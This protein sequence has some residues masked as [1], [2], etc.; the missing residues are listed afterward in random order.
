MAWS[1][2]CGVRT[3]ASWLRTMTK[4]TGLG[5]EHYTNKTGRTTGLGRYTKFE[6]PLL[7][8]FIW[9]VIV[10]SSTDMHI[11]L[12]CMGTSSYRWGGSCESIVLQDVR[13]SYWKEIL[14]QVAIC[15]STNWS[16]HA[17]YRPSS[18]RHICKV[19]IFVLF[20]NTLLPFFFLFISLNSA[21]DFWS[22]YLQFLYY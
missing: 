18:C 6:P 12:Q 3:L 5:G 16:G 9:H 22:P 20:M 2:S 4:E 7:P 19:A 13:E 15:R 11:N 14:L 21:A 1:F 8:W 10:Q 17:C